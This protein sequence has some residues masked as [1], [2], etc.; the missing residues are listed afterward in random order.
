MLGCSVCT[1]L[2]LSGIR[3]YQRCLSPYKGYGCAYRLEYGGS[4]CSGVGYRLIRRYG[5]IRGY[6]ILQK[7]FERCRHANDARRQ[8]VRGLAEPQR[9]DCDCDVPFCDVD[10]DMCPKYK[11]MS[12]LSV[13]FE[14][15]D[16][17]DCS[18]DRGNKQSK[19]KKRRLK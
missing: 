14:F 11:L 10:V 5:V 19:P 9:G 18:F 4:G 6:T 12:K 1:R 8:R 7:R 2:A 15:L 17:C 13:L 3:F 16:C